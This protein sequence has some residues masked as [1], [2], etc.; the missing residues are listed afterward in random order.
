[1]T[2]MIMSK[3]NYHNQTDLC[4][5]QHCYHLCGLYHPSCS[6]ILLSWYIILHLY[7]YLYHP[8]CLVVLLS[9]YIIFHLYLYHPNSLAILLSWYIILHLYLYHPSCLVILLSLCGL[10]PFQSHAP[11]LHHNPEGIK[12]SSPPSSS[13]SS[14]LSMLSSLSLLLLSPTLQCCNSRS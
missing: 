2:Q 10:N 3:K 11:A 8:S 13:L 4:N 14:S 6:A 12:L 9:L 7:L 1:M 5:N